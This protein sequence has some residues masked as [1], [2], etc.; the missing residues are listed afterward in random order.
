MYIYIYIYTHTYT[1]LLLYT[2][3]H[4][5]KVMQ[6][7]L[8]LKVVPWKRAPRTEYI[9]I[10]IYIVCCSLLLLL[11][12]VVVVLSY[13]YICVYVYILVAEAE[14]RALEEGP[15]SRENSKLNQHEAKKRTATNTKNVN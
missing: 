4:A 14:G 12:V 15:S 11:V 8:E 7:F 10:Y 5:P 13:V 2:P 1:L 6:G 9:Y 3:M